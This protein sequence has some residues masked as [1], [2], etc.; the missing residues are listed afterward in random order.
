MSF[1]G[2]TYSPSRDGARLRSQMHAVR[3]LMSDGAWRTLWQIA[4]E[5]EGSESSVSARLRDLR[6][7]KF[8]GHT[9]ERKY[10]GD[11]VWI[12]RLELNG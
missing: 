11:G 12:Y 7:D 8:G 4:K 1:D 2:A 5:V 3:E 9:V 6:K 10:H